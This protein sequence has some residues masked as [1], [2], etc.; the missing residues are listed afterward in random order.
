MKR[1]ALVTVLAV[2]LMLFSAPAG[3]AG[4]WW[5]TYPRITGYNADD[6]RVIDRFSWDGYNHLAIT[7]NDTVVTASAIVMDPNGMPSVWY[8]A[9][10]YPTFYNLYYSFNG[11]TWTY[12][13]QYIYY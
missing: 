9:D 5:A 10:I 1:I 7:W 6:S 2:A 3:E 13:G 4:N 8:W 11:I 12:W